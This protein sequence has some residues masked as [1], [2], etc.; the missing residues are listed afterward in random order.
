MEA[1]NSKMETELR[2]TGKDVMFGGIRFPAIVNLII[3][4]A[5]QFITYARH[6]DSASNMQA[7]RPMLLRMFEMEKV[8][9]KKRG[10]CEQFR[11]RWLPFIRDGVL[12]F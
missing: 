6:R 11:K 5:K 12:C 2:L 3:L 8:I 1:I 10:K 9:A 7:F 4:V